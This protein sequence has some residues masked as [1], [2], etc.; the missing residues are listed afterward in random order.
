MGFNSWRD[1][2]QFERSVKFDRRYLHSDEV[3]EFLNNIKRTLSARRRSVPTGMILWRSQPDFVEDEYEGQIIVRGHDPDRMKPLSNK[4]SEGRANPKGIPYLYLSNDRDTSLAELRPTHGQRMSAAQF[5][6]IRD[7]LVVDCY[8]VPRHYQQ[9]ECIFNPPVSQEEITNATW[10]MINDAFTKPVSRDDTSSDYVPTQ[11]LTEL[12]KA[13]GFDGLCCKSGMGEG[14]NY[15]L[16]NL[17]DA[18]L[19]NCTVME[20]DTVKYSFNECAE[21][22]YINPNLKQE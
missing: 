11:I 22:Y 13:E 6:V 17:D 19:V 18:D 15:V 14:H 5:K 2:E 4:A 8:S 21:R 12:F 20:T 3:E 1:F 16:F 7:L 9:I 10:S